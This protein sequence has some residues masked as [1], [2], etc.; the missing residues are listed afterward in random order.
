M[1]EILSGLNVATVALWAARLMILFGSIILHEVSHGYAAYLLGDPTA[2]R[3]GRLTLNPVKHV[4]PF[5]TIIM[6]AAMLLLSGGSFAFGYAKPVPFDPRYFKNERKGMLI[7]GIAGPASNILIALV[8][9]IILRITLAFAS[10]SSAFLTVVVGLLYYAVIIN[11]ILALF[12]LIPI[13]PLDGSRVVQRF[14]PRKARDAYHQ[15]EP[16]GFVIVIAISWL[17]PAVFDTYLNLTALPLAT[18]FTGIH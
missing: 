12:N 10:A 9:G 11:L 3:M 15:L 5:G 14:L 18:I 4:D 8:C 16:Y 17:L 13:P 6:P 7:T 1:S 2:K